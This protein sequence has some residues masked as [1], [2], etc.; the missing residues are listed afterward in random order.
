M[1]L[2]EIRIGCTFSVT[3]SLGAVPCASESDTTTKAQKTLFL[4]CP[5]EKWTRSG[6]ARVEVAA[7]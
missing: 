5:A 4:A 7:F 3:S 1:W 6:A 2:R